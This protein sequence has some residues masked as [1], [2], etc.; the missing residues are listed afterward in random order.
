MAE[1][2]IHGGAFGKSHLAKCGKTRG[3]IARDGERCVHYATGIT[4]VTCRKCIKAH[5]PGVR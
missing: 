5:K 4:L 1:K 2:L 3:A